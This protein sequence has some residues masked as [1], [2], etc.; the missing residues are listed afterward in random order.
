M[1]RAFKSG[2]KISSERHRRKLQRNHRRKLRN[3]RSTIDN[4]PPKRHTHLRKNKK[5][6]QMMQERFA[7]IERENQLLLKKMS[8]IMRH[9]TLDNKCKAARYTHSLNKGLRKKELKKISEENMA[10]LARIQSR[11]STYNHL[12]WEDERRKNEALLSMISEYDLPKM[13]KSYR[14][15][16][17]MKL[18]RLVGE[19]EEEEEE[20]DAFASTRGGRHGRLAPLR[21]ES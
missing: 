14:T 5:K 19:K 6:K 20:E 8:Y 12:K 9:D 10:I 18:R 1:H 2:N 21:P 3:I 4:K 13:S 11:E 7:K 15:R 16:S 17:V